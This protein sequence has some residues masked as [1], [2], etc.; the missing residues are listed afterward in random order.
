MKKIP[1][2]HICPN[3]GG[4][5]YPTSKLCYKCY[6]ESLGKK[7]RR[8]HHRKDACPQCGKP[9]LVSSELCFSCSKGQLFET[10]PGLADRRKAIARKPDFDSI[11]DA[12]MYYFVGL[13]MG[14]GTVRFHR[15]KGGTISVTMN[16]KLRADDDA[17]IVDIWKKLG[18]G[19]GIHNSH[20][21]IK[22]NPTSDWRLCTQ[23]TIWK[24]LNLIVPFLEITP[25]KKAKEI[26]LALE[27]LEWR[28]D[29]PFHNLDRAKCQEFYDRM[30]ELRRY[31]GP[32]V[33]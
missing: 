17:V 30:V 1:E 18:G 15:N 19:Y 25:A 12:W 16:M 26:F 32:V 27:Y 4:K 7:G 31:K 11:T 28:Q 3:C 6:R 24:T 14:E 2:L 10:L 21:S 8:T 20:R 29:Q 33:D 13:F 22:A 5:K 9:K 23:D